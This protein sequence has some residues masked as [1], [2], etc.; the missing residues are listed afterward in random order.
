MMKSVN[1]RR[2]VVGITYNGKDAKSLEQFLETFSYVDESNGAG[3]TI[4]IQLHNLDKRWLNEW[5]PKK[6]DNLIAQIKTYNW[7]VQYQNWYK[8]RKTKSS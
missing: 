4:D 7:N 6:S 2:T 3:D 1:T 8:E 5:F